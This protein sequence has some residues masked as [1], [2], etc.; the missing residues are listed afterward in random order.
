M[1]MEKE[2][3]SVFEDIFPLVDQMTRLVE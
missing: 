1:I 2:V 3:G